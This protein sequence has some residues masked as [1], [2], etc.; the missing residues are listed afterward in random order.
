MSR[1]QNLAPL[2]IIWIDHILIEKE[3]VIEKYELLVEYAI[4]NVLNKLWSTL[5]LTYH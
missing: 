1:L 3:S 2:M 5:P 4:S